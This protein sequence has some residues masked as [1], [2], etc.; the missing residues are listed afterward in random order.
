MPKH[1]ELAEEPAEPNVEPVLGA[2]W[3]RGDEGKM[4]LLRG[5]VSPLPC[6]KPT[7]KA[8]ANVSPHPLALVPCLKPTPQILPTEGDEA[9]SSTE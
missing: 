8:A 2:A 3:C 5:N 7:P 1:R 4:E 9:S 6:L